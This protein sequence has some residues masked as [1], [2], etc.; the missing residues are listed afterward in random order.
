MLKKLEGGVAQKLRRF[1]SQNSQASGSS[2]RS[3]SAT[4]GSEAYSIEG[5]RLSRT[6]T[7]DDDFRKKLEEQFQRKKKEDDEE[8]EKKMKRTSVNNSKTPQQIIDYVELNDRD[9]EAAINDLMKDG[10]GSENAKD[11]DAQ[12]RAAMAAQDTKKS[13]KMF[14]HYPSQVHARS[15]LQQPTA[16]FQNATAALKSSI[17]P[18]ESAISNHGR[19]GIRGG[20]QKIIGVMQSAQKAEQ[21]RQTTKSLQ[22]T[23]SVQQSRKQTATVRPARPASYAAVSA[24]LSDDY[25]PFNY[26]VYPSRSSIHSNPPEAPATTPEVELAEEE[27]LPGVESAEAVTVRKAAPEIVDTPAQNWP[28]VD[29]G[30]NEQQAAAVTAECPQQETAIPQEAE[31][32]EET[33]TPAPAPAPIEIVKEEPKPAPVATGWAARFQPKGGPQKVESVLKSAGIALTTDKP[34]PKEPEETDV[35]PSPA[36]KSEPKPEVTEEPKISEIQSPPHVREGPQKPA[37]IME[38]ASAAAHQDTGAPDKVPASKDTAADTA[39]NMTKTEDVEEVTPKHEETIEKANAVQKHEKLKA[40]IENLAVAKASEPSSSPEVKPISNEL[41]ESSLPVQ[42]AS[43][44]ETTPKRQT[45][46]SLL[47]SNGSVK[48]A[49]PCSSPKSPKEFN[50]AA[51]PRLGT[52]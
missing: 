27:V 3:Q 38:A 12:A 34:A 8:R 4:R 39:S 23:T 37:A 16:V 5:K 33:L 42:K 10:K 50:A 2:S 20:P 7:T 30:T 11:L 40:P 29:T 36:A 14:E 6:I 25:D 49:S 1:E 26:A 45:P 24:P 43:T 13:G 22:R 31:N 44:S 35:L 17:S 28:A 46:S 52:A 41:P 18:P 47:L 21:D 51:L 48:T 32:V 9:R 15:S 19:L